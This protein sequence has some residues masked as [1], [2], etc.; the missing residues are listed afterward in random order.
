NR[1]STFRT[2]ILLTEPW[3]RADPALPVAIVESGSTPRQR[4]TRAPLGEIVERA[5]Q[6]GVRAP[7][8]IVVGDVAAEGRL[9]PATV[10]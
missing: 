8:I 5:A 10:A 7:A 6:S 2:P 9:D 1:L 3:R 4:V